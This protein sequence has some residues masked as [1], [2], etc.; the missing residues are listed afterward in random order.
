MDGMR[1]RRKRMRAADA[2]AVQ[3]SA[4]D[5]TAAA[6]PIAATVQAVQP[7]VSP[8]PEPE[9]IGARGFEN[10]EE[11]SRALRHACAQRAAEGSQAHVTALCQHAFKQAADHVRGE[12]SNVA[13]AFYAMVDQCPNAIANAFTTSASAD[14]GSKQMATEQGIRALVEAE[15]VRLRAALQNKREQRQHLLALQEQVAEQQAVVEIVRQQRERDAAM[16]KAQAGPVWPDGL[17]TAPPNLHPACDGHTYHSD[18]HPQA[19]TDLTL[20]VRPPS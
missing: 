1:V 8:S 16:R 3:G 14:P 4:P 5:L 6:T 15:K 13:A 18:G 20:L 11:L 9:L 2:A 19:E 17:T 7:R 12:S 10:A